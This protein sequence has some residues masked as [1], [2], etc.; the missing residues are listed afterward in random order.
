M[1]MYK[2]FRTIAL[3]KTQCTVLNSLTLKNVV[4]PWPQK[5]AVRTIK[6]K[7]IHDQH[8]E[9]LPS[10]EAQFICLLGFLV[11]LSSEFIC[12]VDFSPSHACSILTFLLS[13]EV[14]ISPLKGSSMLLAIR[15]HITEGRR[16]F[17]R[18]ASPLSLGWQLATPLGS[19][20]NSCWLPCYCPE[21]C[22]WCT[23]QFV[24]V[25]TEVPSSEITR[26]SAQACFWV[27]KTCVVLLGHIA[28][29]RIRYQQW[30]K[31]SGKHT[32]FLTFIRR[33][34]LLSD[35]TLFPPASFHLQHR[36]C[37]LHL[38][39]DFCSLYLVI[40]AFLDC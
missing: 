34:G 3:S 35:L 13:C 7:I 22:F 26:G 21:M 32:F 11:R 19:A 15:A 16:V 24:S 38:P 40:D 33:V 17:R 27:S 8:F 28:Q 29:A 20:H 30:I 6:C 5:M 23:K 37:R 25:M 4:K 14:L 12:V 36:G 31:K 1:C 2:C 18:E 39:S 10:K 9:I